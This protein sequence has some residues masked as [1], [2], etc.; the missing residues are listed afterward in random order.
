MHKLID[1]LLHLDRR[2]NIVL[3]FA[4]RYLGIPLV[5]LLGLLSRKN[6]EIPKVV[7][8]IGILGNAAI[9][10][11][12]ISSAPIADMRAEL[13]GVK[14]VLFA[15]GVDCATICSMISGLDAVVPISM[16]HP[17]E[18]IRT[19]RRHGPF[20]IR[21]EFCPWPRTN[22]AVSF[23]APASLRVG[24]KT[25]G[26]Y[27]HA[28]YDRTAA[29]GNDVH[30]VVNYRRLLAAAGISGSHIPALHPQRTTSSVPR[31]VMHVTAGGTAAAMKMWPEPHWI[32]LIDHVIAGGMPVV[33]TGS[34]RDR[35]HLDNLRNRC[36]DP[37]QIENAAG[38]LS[39]VET[40]ELLA[41]S[42]AVVSIDS[43]VMHLAAALNCKLLAL[44]GATSP[45]RWG[46]LN[47]HARV[48]YTNR[49]CSP[50]VS[51]GLEKGCG[52]NRC[53]GDLTP[54]AVIQE[55]DLLIARA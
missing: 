9:G 55:L 31:I 51:L 47:T 48:L 12:V 13:P 28:V 17:V 35:E 34:G 14:L 21:Y 33:L 46:P 2:P 44:F 19:I 22:A 38:L 40:A 8:S 10:D 18:T 25:P 50:C 43:G 3:R 24:F 54:E 32:S 6:A 52:S 36:H 49:D 42:T 20:D 45:R 29:H 53:L 30:E 7:R 26:Q 16:N 11:T 39:L 4:D 23:F 41:S 27:R 5:V 1:A 37:S 15:P